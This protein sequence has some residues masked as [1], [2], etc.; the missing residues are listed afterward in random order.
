MRVLSL[1]KIEKNYQ[2]Q[3]IRGMIDWGTKKIPR[4]SNNPPPPPKK[5]FLQKSNPKKSHAELL[6]IKNIPKFVFV[7]S[8][9]HPHLVVVLTTLETPGAQ[10]H[11]EYPKKSLL[12]SSHPK[13]TCQIFLPKKNQ[14]RKFQ[15]PK[16]SFAHPCHL[17]SRVP[18]WGIALPHLLSQKGGTVR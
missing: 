7:Y 11:F 14:N 5:K 9:Y 1:K 6:R 15:T 2:K 16:K 4:A 10:E 18:S 17:K 12:K 3:I 8:S 13:N